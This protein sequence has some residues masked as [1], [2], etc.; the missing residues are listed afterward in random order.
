MVN[1]GDSSQKTDSSHRAVTVRKG[2]TSQ[3]PVSNHEVATTPAKAGH[4]RERG[5]FVQS[6]ASVAVQYLTP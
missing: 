3:V 4:V 1:S 5:M 6:C 2:P